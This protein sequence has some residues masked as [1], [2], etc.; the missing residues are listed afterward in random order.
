MVG[1]KTSNAMVAV[2]QRVAR[3]SVQSED[4]NES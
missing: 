2:M 3:V 1:E 4:L